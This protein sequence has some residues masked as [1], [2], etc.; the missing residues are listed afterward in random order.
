MVLEHAAERGVDEAD[1]ELLLAERDERLRPVDRLG[2]AGDLREVG[3]L[4]SALDERR[5]L[6]G[7]PL[8]DARHAGAHD[9]DLALERRVPDPVVEAAA[10]ERVVQ[11]ARAVRGEDHDG[12]PRGADR[13]D[14]RDRDLEVGEELEQERLELVVRAVDL[15][16]QQHRR[17][18][19]VVLDRVEQRP[20]DE[21]LAAEEVVETRCATLAF[22]RDAARLDQS[23]SQSIWRA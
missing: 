18:R 12:P 6:G 9:R 2:D 13:A 8:G 3:Q 22:R 17:H 15:V 20:A 10:L 19:V 14:L 7:E 11:L 1:L 23:G 5:G 4:R 16:D 21:E